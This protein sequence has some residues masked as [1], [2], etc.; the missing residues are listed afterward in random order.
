VFWRS[1]ILVGASLIAIGSILSVPQVQAKTAVEVGD[2]AKTITVSISGDTGQGSG[3]ILQRQGDLYTVLTAAHVVRKTKAYTITTS[4]NRQHRSIDGSIQL[5]ANNIDLAIVQFRT[6]GRYTIAKVGNSQQLRSGM[7]LY[8]AGF[9]AA[10]RAMTQSTFVFRE[11]KVSANSDREFAD[12]YSL[13]YSNDTLPGMSGGAILNTEG[14]LVAIHGKGDREELGDGELGEKT[15]F[16]VGIPIERLATIAQA[17]STK[18][19]LRIPPKPSQPQRAPRADDYIAAGTRK[20]RD[21][22]FN[23]SLAD[24]NRALSLDSQAAIAYYYRG[25]IKAYKLKARD[26]R[27]ALADYDRAIQIDPRMV[28]AYQYRGLLKDK[29][30]KDNAGAIADF[31]RAIA[32]NPKSATAYYYRANFKAYTDRH[33]NYQSALADLE[34]AV[35]LDPNSAV[36]YYY[37]GLLKDKKLNDDRGAFADYSRAIS[38]NPSSSGAYRQRGRIV[39]FKLKDPNGGIADLDRAIEIAP[40]D[41]GSYLNRGNIKAKLTQ[42]FKG[43]LADFD[44]AIAL[45]PNYA[46]AYGLRAILKEQQFKDRAAAIADMQTSAR[47]YQQQGDLKQY[48]WATNYLQ[49][50]QKSSGG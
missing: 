14:E 17:S 32:L 9:P 11:G 1:K 29:K 37:R 46:N 13:V 40:K 45:N 43:A 33:P 4:D 26:I 18:L 22:D 36:A 35:Q 28:V 23:G 38:L 10:T 30:L 2:I 7:D 50:W 49:K 25:N 39:A 48:Q 31:D 47:I 44:R 12:G 8:V 20:Y 16:N 15:G 27:G 34:L 41:Y 42:D 19:A 6:A 21:R 5:A 24:F 3:V